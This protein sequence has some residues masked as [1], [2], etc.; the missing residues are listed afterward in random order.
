VF[1][2]EGENFRRPYRAE[3]K[4][5]YWR[6]DFAPPPIINQRK[7]A[8]VEFVIFV[9]GGNPSGFLAPFTKITNRKKRQR[10]C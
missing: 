6:R 9:D 5:D 2:N 7:T 10:V 4:I 1:Q 3:K 8:E